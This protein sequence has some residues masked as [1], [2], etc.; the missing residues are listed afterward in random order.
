M[1]MTL[2]DEMRQPCASAMLGM[3]HVILTLRDLGQD[4]LADQLTHMRDE[5]ARAVNRGL[6]RYG[7]VRVMPIDDVRMVTSAEQA[8]Q[9]LRADRRMRHAG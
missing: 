9:R 2:H 3:S 5:W 1:A 7:R 6:K 8:R 4:E